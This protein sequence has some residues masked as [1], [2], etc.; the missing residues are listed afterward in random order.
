MRVTFPLRGVVNIKVLG[1]SSKISSF[2]HQSF[3]HHLQATDNNG[4]F[5]TDVEAV[6]ITVFLSELKKK[7]ATLQ[8]FKQITGV[9][10]HYIKS[11]VW[12]L[13]FITASF[14]LRGI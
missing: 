10:L 3:L 2:C 4:R 14:T 13:C 6:D 5:A 8:C 7:Q 12:I 9:L 11:N 1:S